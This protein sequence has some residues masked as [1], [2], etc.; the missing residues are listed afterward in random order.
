VAALP[1]K[2]KVVGVVSGRLTEAGAQLDEAY[3]GRLSEA[4]KTFKFRGE[5]GS[6]LV[7]LTEDAAVMLLGLGGKRGVDA[8]R[9]REAGAKVAKKAI[10]LGAREV[11]VENFFADRLGR[12]AATYALAEGLYLGSYRF[13]RYK[14][15][16]RPVR[17][18]YLI[19]RGR[20]RQLDQAE[21]LS[22]ATFYARDL[23]NE[24]PNALNPETLAAVAERLAEEEGFEVKVYREKE[25]EEMG[26]GALLAVG[27]GA[28][29]PPVLIHL[30]YR[31][32]GAKRRVALVGKGLCFDTGGYSLKPTQNMRHMKADMAGAAA[33][34]GAMRA[35]ARLGAP[36]EVHGVIAAAENKISGNA[37]VVDEVIRTFSGKTVEVK[38]TDAEGRLAL[39][40][41]LGYIAREAPEAVVSVATLT[42]SAV[43]A[44]GRAV[45]A[46]FASDERLGE[47]IRRAGALEGEKL[48][49]MP[50]EPSYER[51]LKSDVADIANVGT[52]EGGAIQAALFLKNF[53]RDPFVHLDIAGTAFRP[54]AWE[55][56]PAGAT[57]FGVRTLARWLLEGAR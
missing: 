15:E 40:D 20:G 50:L 21:V 19:A 32:E 12:D 6:E 18:R 10:E 22:E 39:A 31:P 11:A 4:I 35:A 54:E 37:Y 14:S 47:G 23:V 2:L 46:L 43:V 27:R 41:A 33:V 45:A 9:V 25:L 17:V 53:V 51:H 30:V 52:R 16:S 5:F 26:M 1:A 38:N 36:V 49:P 8:A 34:L 42:G 13:D 48:W 57:G 56:G 28:A 24:P 55:L 29:V 7:F 3:S 44:L